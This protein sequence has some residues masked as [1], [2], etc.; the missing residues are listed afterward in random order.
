[1]HEKLSHPFVRKQSVFKTVYEI[2][3]LAFNFDFDSL[4]LPHCVIIGVCS[5]CLFVLKNQGAKKKKEKNVPLNGF[6]YIFKASF[7]VLFLFM[8]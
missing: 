6:S 7:S 8:F 5:R 2:V 3:E 4:L 1:M